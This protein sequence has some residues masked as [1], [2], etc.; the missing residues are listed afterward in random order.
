MVEWYRVHGEPEGEEGTL[1][2]IEAALA[3]NQRVPTRLEITN[4]YLRGRP[5]VFEL[6]RREL[7]QAGKWKE[8][9]RVGSRPTRRKLT[10]YVN[11]FLEIQARSGQRRVYASPRPMVTL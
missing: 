2:E 5:V 4:N 8:R 6:V 3:S 9:F 7:D 11:S 10:D 1:A